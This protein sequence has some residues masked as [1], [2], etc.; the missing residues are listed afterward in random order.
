[1]THRDDYKNTFYRII[2]VSSAQ[3]TRHAIFILFQ[4]S[5]QIEDCLR[6]KIF[7]DLREHPATDAGTYAADTIRKSENSCASN[8]PQR[9]AR[10]P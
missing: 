5:F 7:M 4:D 6:I 9:V 10:S 2:Y 1:M 8:M 3:G